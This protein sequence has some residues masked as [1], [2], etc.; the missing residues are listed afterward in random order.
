MQH[1]QYR[2]F[3]AVAS[4]DMPAEHLGWSRPGQGTWMLFELQVARTE[5]KRSLVLKRELASFIVPVGGEVGRV[6][7]RTRRARDRGHAGA[8]A[9]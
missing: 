1:V 3:S 6:E 4:L 7:A 2:D 5:G 8:A 9:G